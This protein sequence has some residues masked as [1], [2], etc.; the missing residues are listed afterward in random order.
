LSVR[1]L[2]QRRVYSGDARC[3]EHYLISL[4]PML[5]QALVNGCLINRHTVC[6]R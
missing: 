4:E 6:T 5:N 3:Y 1:V 2:R